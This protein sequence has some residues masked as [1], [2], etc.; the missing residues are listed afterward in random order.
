MKRVIRYMVSVM[1]LILPALP[2]QA[3]SV[4]DTRTDTATEAMCSEI[5]QRAWD[6]L[7]TLCDDT[8]RNQACYG[9]M[10][11]DAQPQPDVIRFA[12]EQEGEKVDVAD[13]QSLRLS[14]MDLVSG[15]WGVAL[16]Q[17]K[18]N[19]PATLSDQ[20]V[21]L[22]LFGDVEIE[23]AGEELSSVEVTPASPVNTLNIRYR[24]STQAAI[25]GHIAPGE[26]MVANGQLENGSWVRV[27]LPDRSIS[28][29]LYAPL[30]TSVDDKPLDTLQ[31]VDTETTNYGPMQAFYFQSG[32]QDSQCAEAPNSG[33]L[34]QTPEGVAE[35]TLLIN[36][37]DIQLGSTVYFQS[38]L[39][40]EMTVSVVEGKARVTAFGETQI[41]FAGTQVG[42]PMDI[43]GKASGTP[44][45]PRPYS[46]D[47]L[48]SLPV[49][50]MAIP[51]TIAE[52]LSE[53]DIEAA[54][55][56]E[57]STASTTSDDESDGNNGNN[58][59]PN[60]SDGAPPPGLDGIYPPGQSEDSLPP[61]QGGTPPGQAKKQ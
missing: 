15:N 49:S 50:H 46:M 39:G 7:D 20:N 31:V 26:S 56:Q 11:L 43:N 36:E 59:Q 60:P 23:N 48:A 10:L 25:V 54:L 6:N 55:V 28:G 37:V 19:L 47:S 58:G 53:T 13:L 14:T 17:I 29:W 34:I 9:H 61:G 44:T 42:I 18:A 2:A 12:F 32:G 40:G 21:S 5:V 33:I 3:T 8:N 51:V 30:I 22:L 57:L 52:P 4:S 45:P 16:M 27:E 35:V 41:A 24:P 38:E 1:V